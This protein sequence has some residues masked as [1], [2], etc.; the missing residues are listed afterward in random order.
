MARIRIGVGNEAKPGT[1]QKPW[2]EM[3]LKYRRQRLLSGW[4]R[5]VGAPFPKRLY[6][7]CHGWRLIVQIVLLSL[8]ARTSSLEAFGQDAVRMSMA[9]ASAAESRQTANGTAGYYN[10]Q[11][12][13]TYWRFGSGLSLGYNSNVELAEGKQEGDFIY[14]PSLSVQMK[15]PISQ[16]QALNIGVGLGYSGYAQ[17]SS[18]NTFFVTPN[19]GVAFDIYAG[20]FVIEL[21]DRFTISQGSYQDP[22][23][24]GRGNYSEF[25]NSAGTLVTWDLNKMVVS[26]G[27]DYA[28]SLEVSGGLGQPNQGN[29]VFSG[30]AGLVLKPG[31]TT[32]IEAGGSLQNYSAATT[33]NPYSTAIQWNAGAFFKTQVTEHISMNVDAGYV[34]N[35]PESSGALS[36]AQ[37]FAGYYANLGVAHRVNR[38]VQ[39]SLGVGRNVS[40]TYFGGATDAYTANLSAGWSFIHKVSLSTGFNYERGTEVGFVGGE[41]Y[42][43]YGPTISVGRALTKKMNAGLVYQFVD[44][45]A[46]EAL[47]KYTLNIVTLSLSYQF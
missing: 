37:Q 34:V 32:G 21:H 16:L 5:N 33:N 12:G 41:T 9:S 40:D 25:Q 2:Y 13:P 30:S 24:T 43:Q 17:H 20:D 29:E 26:L 19:S 45:N 47:Q 6:R 11:A 14:S 46:N 31:M 42:Y 27:Y 23:V 39:Y 28:S 36:T 7:R 35:S 44:R 22:T 4:R 15:W 18:L 1:P 3:Y 38:F 8:L 10:L